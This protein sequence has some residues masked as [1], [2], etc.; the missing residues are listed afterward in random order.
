MG[1]DE[2]DFAIAGRNHG[3]LLPTTVGV[4]QLDGS[5]TPRTQIS[6]VEG[7]ECPLAASWTSSSSFGNRNFCAIP[8]LL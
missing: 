2:I 8:K 4:L 1:G 3:P 5:I 7:T 6:L